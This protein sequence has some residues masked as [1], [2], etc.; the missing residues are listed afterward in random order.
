M[1]EY[2]K[3]DTFETSIN[4]VSENKIREYSPLTLAYIGDTVYDLYIRAYLVKN[5]MGKVQDLHKYA[6]SV[7]NARAQAT[8]AKLLLSLFTEREHEIFRSGKNSKSAPPKNMS[9]KDY[10]YATGLEA[11][12]GYLYCIG[13]KQRLNDLFRIIIQH[14][15]M[16]E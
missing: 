10:S 15:Y 7:V 3:A 2:E 12:V 8:A 4:D 5:R 14:F 13:E 9:V 1:K 11:V 16:E 6:S